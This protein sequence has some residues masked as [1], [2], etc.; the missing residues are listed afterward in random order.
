MF[1][2]PENEEFV[3]SCAAFLILAIKWKLKLGNIIQ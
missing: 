2:I 3:V 1:D